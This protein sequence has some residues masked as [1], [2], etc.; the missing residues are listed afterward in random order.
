VEKAHFQRV[1]LTPKTL[2]RLYRS[3][4]IRSLGLFHQGQDVIGLPARLQLPA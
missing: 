1:E 4:Q 2:G 3:L